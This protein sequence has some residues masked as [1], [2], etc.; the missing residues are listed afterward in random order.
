MSTD[1]NTPRERPKNAAQRLYSDDFLTRLGT[2]FGF[3]GLEPELALELRRSARFYLAHREQSKADGVNTDR[4]EYRAL[5]KAALKFIEII[6]AAQDDSDIATDMYITARN[7]KPGDNPFGITDLP[8]SQIEGRNDRHYRHL[9]VLTR[10]LVEA[11]KHQGDVVKLPSGPRKNVALESLVQSA[12]YFWSRYLGRKFTV[13]YH[14]GSG[15]TEAFQF[16]RTLLEPFG[17]IIG[18]RQIITAMRAEI[19]SRNAREKRF[20][21]AN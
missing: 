17:D 15:L 18:D 21:R 16:V 19:K 7:L 14:Q 8:E 9:L 3:D 10:L 20:T 2:R 1:T 12:S 6:E 11:I 5:Q 13:D 4:Q